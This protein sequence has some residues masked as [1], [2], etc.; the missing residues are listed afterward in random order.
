VL[1][2]KDVRRIGAGLLAAAAALGV[3]AHGSK[4]WPVPESAKRMA[5]PVKAS[6]AVLAAAR[7]I[8]AEMCAQCHGEQGKGDGTEAMMYSVKP[9]NFAE[10][11]MMG[12]MTDGEIF[13]K[14]TEGRRPMPG[15]KN[16]LSEEQRWQMVH[17][18]RSLARPA[19]A[20]AKQPAKKSATHKH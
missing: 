7:K 8:Y 18:V 9:A 4:P 16:T 13:Y 3:V 11:H 19:T 12:E 17:F 1:R 20:A 10:E 2:K 5:N 6:P 14:M 15:F